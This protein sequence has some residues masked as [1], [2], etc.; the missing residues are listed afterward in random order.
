M[1]KRYSVMAVLMLG[2]VSV[3][4]QA[5]QPPK[6]KAGLWEMQMQGGNMGGQQAPD[7]AQMQ[8]AMQ[9][10]QARLAQM[11]PEQ[12]K[13]VEAQMGGMGM[14]MG[15]NGGVR[16]CLTEEDIKRD[17]IPV[18][19]GKCASQ[20]KSRT[21][22]R[23]VMTHACTDPVTS[24]EAEVVFEGSQAY[25]VHATGSVT[26]NGQKQPYDMRMR[27]QHVSADCGNVKPASEAH[28]QYQQQMQKMQQ[29]M[30]QRP[31]RY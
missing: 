6:L 4:A 5:A 10:M 3:G 24:G 17:A 21:A 31:S 20:V 16:I 28:K 8:Q 14:S 26:R 12:R 29:Q 15:G 13:M 18:S 19:D 1:N 7:M 23:W 2:L 11:P 27:M 9:K 22:N 25:S 30:Q